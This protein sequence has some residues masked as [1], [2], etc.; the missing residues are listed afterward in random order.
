MFVM[1]VRHCIL[2]WWKGNALFSLLLYSLVWPEVWIFPYLTILQFLA[3]TKWVSYHSV[4]LWYYLPG[5]NVGSHKTVPTS[6]S[7]C[8]SQ[9]VTCTSDQP[10]INEVLLGFD[11][12]LEQ[13]T[14]FRKRV[15]LLDFWFI[16]KGCNSGTT[17]WKRCIVSVGHARRGVELPCLL[18]VCHPPSTPLCSLTWKLSEPHALGILIT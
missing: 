16:I 1:V 11:S 12:L 6:S 13:L 10:T 7:N 18:Q 3:D 17:R 2:W 15:Y 14:E 8:K 5:V 4:Q 9:V